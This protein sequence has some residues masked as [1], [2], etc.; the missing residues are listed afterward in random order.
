MFVCYT[1]QALDDAKNRLDEILNFD[2]WETDVVDVD[3]EKAEVLAIY[4]VSL[5]SLSLYTVYDVSDC[6]CYG[7]SAFSV[8][9]SGARRRS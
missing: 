4:D 3:A 2:K 1:Y 9:I 6:M 8:C 7:S 5:Q